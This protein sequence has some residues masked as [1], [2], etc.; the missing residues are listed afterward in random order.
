MD[1][2]TQRDF[3]FLVKIA[4]A[5]AGILGVKKLIN[6]FKEKKQNKKKK[7]KKKKK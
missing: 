7:N 1:K 3:A 2:A 6:H 4:G 5:F